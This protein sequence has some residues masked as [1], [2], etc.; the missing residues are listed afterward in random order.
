MEYEDVSVEMTT[1]DHFAEQTGLL[2]KNIAMW[3]DLEGCAYEALTGATQALKTTSAIMVE[4][5]DKPYWNGQKTSADVHN[6]LAEAGF[7]AVGRDFEYDGQ[8]NVVF[9]SSAAYETSWGRLA[10]ARGYSAA[11]RLAAP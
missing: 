8:Y 3:I 10:L 1:V 5:E 4:V 9:I 11:K 7:I 6:L 2:G